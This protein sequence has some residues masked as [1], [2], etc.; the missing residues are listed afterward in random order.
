MMAI[1]LKGMKT[2]SPTQLNQAVL[3]VLVQIVFH[4]EKGGL[5]TL[6][7]RQQRVTSDPAAPHNPEKQI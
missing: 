6:G 5:Q 4:L 7:L 1:T 2:H 3:F